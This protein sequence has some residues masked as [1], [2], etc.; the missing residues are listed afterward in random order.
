[1][2]LRIPGPPLRPAARLL[3]LA[4][5]LLSAR[6]ASAVPA[7]LT[8]SEMRT[9]ASLRDARARADLLA[10]GRPGAGQVER[11]EAAFLEA[12]SGAGWTAARYEEADTLVEDVLATLRAMKAEPSA[13]RKLR[14]ELLTRV[15]A[16]TVDR[17]KARRASLEGAVERARRAAASG[18]KP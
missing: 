16:A 15:D 10:T 1:M 2:A 6:P 4:A 7:G 13:A 18:A 5:L 17:V 8:E 12:L 14:E 3:A 11:G 9:Y